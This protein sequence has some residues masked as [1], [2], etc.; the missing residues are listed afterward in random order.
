MAV[1]GM[2]NRLRA[3]SSGLRLAQFLGRDYECIWDPQANCNFNYQDQ[4]EPP[5]PVFKSG[6][7]WRNLVTKANHGLTIKSQGLL[8]KGTQFTSRIVKG[9]VIPGG[10]DVT[11]IEAGNWFF[12]PDD[13][14][15]SSFEQQRALY[16]LHTP[17]PFVIA[18]IN[19]IHLDAAA[20]QRL[21]GVHIRGT[22]NTHCREHSPPEV[23]LPVVDKKLEGGGRILLATDDVRAADMFKKRYGKK[24][25]IASP[26]PVERHTTAGMKGAI[27]DLYVL[28]RCDAIIGT[29]GSTYSHAAMGLSRS[30]DLSIAHVPLQRGMGQICCEYGYY[31]YDWFKSVITTT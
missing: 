30:T 6:H 18:D 2:C 7:W 16:R 23:F 26:P 29:C 14:F 13:N 21:I 1:C 25:T 27:K 24:L 3:V 15:F 28:A 19:A 22:D 4:F 5:F 20:G 17:K 10:E 8:F 11:L 9:N 12:H 31:D